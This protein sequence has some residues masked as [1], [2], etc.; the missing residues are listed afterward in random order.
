MTVEA[1]REVDADKDI[2]VLTNNLIIASIVLVA[3]QLSYLLLSIAIPRFFM[4]DGSIIDTQVR[5]G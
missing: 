2:I 3:G 4:M 1:M 5:K